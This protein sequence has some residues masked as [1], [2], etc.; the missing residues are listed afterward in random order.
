MWVFLSSNFLHLDPTADFVNNV[1]VTAAVIVLVVL[2][3]R[4][5]ITDNNAH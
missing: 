5:T 2:V 1:A 4:T 3:W